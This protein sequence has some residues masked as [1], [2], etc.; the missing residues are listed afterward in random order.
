LT[1][2]L[3]RPCLI[4][5]VSV[6]VLSWITLSIKSIRA[7]DNVPLF[8]GLKYLGY[9]A[10]LGGVYSGLDVIRINEGRPVDREFTEEVAAALGLAVLVLGLSEAGLIASMI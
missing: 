10:T 7:L 3:T 1:E 8:V 2:P 6:A 9:A 5:G 4:L